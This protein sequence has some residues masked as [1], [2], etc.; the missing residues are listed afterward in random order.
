MNK[1]ILS[2]IGGIALAL[3]ALIRAIILIINVIKEL[4]SGVEVLNV[5]ELNYNAL[6]LIIGFALICIP[7]IARQLSGA[8]SVGIFV[9]LVH[10]AI[11]TIDYCGMG[12]KGVEAAAMPLYA[13][14][15]LIPLI[16]ILVL[17]VRAQRGA[18]AFNLYYL[19][20]LIYFICNAVVFAVNLINLSEI[21][22]PIYAIIE[23]IFYALV[24]FCM[25]AFASERMVKQKKQPKA[26]EIRYFYY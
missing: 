25:G 10:N 15:S 11:N 1:K 9:L 20:M 18:N 6:I 2:L 12:F 26:N 5:L 4:N 7:M 14:A 3:G 17:A 8:F 22:S 19:P 13:C 23:Y 16:L 21:I 24:Y